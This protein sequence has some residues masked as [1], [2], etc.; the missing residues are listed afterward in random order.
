MVKK[1]L[2]LAILL[3]LASCNSD[4]VSTE[5]SEI[6]PPFLDE[7][8]VFTNVEI[9]CGMPDDTEKPPSPLVEMEGVIT[10]VGI[11]CEMPNDSEIPAYFVADTDNEY[12]EAPVITYESDDFHDE[13][14]FGMKYYFVFSG[15]LDFWDRPVDVYGGMQLVMNEFK[16][17]PIPDYFYEPAQFFPIEHINPWLIDIAVSDDGRIIVT[18]GSSGWPGPLRDPANDVD[19][20]LEIFVSVRETMREEDSIRLFGR[21]N[22]LTQIPGFYEDNFSNDLKVSIASEEQVILY[23]ERENSRVWQWLMD[24]ENAWRI[25]V[26]DPR[27]FSDIL[28]DVSGDLWENHGIQIFLFAGD[29][30]IVSRQGILSQFPEW[31]DDSLYFDLHV[32]GGFDMQYIMLHEQPESNLWQLL[33]D[34][35]G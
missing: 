25:T 19:I 1:M 15:C 30:T 3:L 6:P 20:D 33:I 4:A 32:C 28:Q 18:G 7:E 11:D 14:Q 24:E 16:W 12:D 31:Q 29:A 22:G 10:D 26:N 8:E 21:N 5:K 35:K 23:E 34:M 9:D 17:W 2:F 27:P 13:R